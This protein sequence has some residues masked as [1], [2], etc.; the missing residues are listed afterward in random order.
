MF[1]LNFT[2]VFLLHMK[3]ILMP[4]PNTPSLNKYI[5]SRGRNNKYLR[6]QI[7]TMLK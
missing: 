7:W 5:L 1:Y 2:L 3:D 6:V 4:A